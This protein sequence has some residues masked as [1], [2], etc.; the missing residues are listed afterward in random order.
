ML[1][2]VD[3]LVSVLVTLN[4]STEATR[5]TPTPKLTTLKKP[6]SILLVTGRTKNWNR[7]QQQRSV[8][9]DDH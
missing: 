6:L 5:A 8:F 1:G 9:G 2:V 3:V 4:T 7:G